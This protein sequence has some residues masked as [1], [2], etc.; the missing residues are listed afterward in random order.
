MIS[1]AL[2]TLR[3]NCFRNR[4]MLASV[5]YVLCACSEKK[6]PAYEVFV[7]DIFRVRLIKMYSIREILRYKRNNTVAP[8]SSEVTEAVVGF[9]IG[10]LD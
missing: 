6:Y 3:D 9:N 8:L 5:L 10:N 2:E 1:Y 7:N 4:L